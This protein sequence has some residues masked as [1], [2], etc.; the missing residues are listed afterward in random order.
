MVRDQIISRYPDE[1]ALSSAA[2]R[3]Q[4][5]AQS[6]LRLGI[7]LVRSLLLGDTFT[8]YMTGSSNTAGH[9]N[10]FMSTWPMQFQSMMRPVWKRVGYKGA[11]FVVKNHAEGGG[12]G[13]MELGPCIPSLIGD[14]A[15]V[16]W[17]ESRMNDH[18]DAVDHA[19]ENHFRNAITLPRRPLYHIMT[20]GK[21]G[22]YHPGTWETDGYSGSPWVIDPNKGLL[23]E[24]YN[25]YVLESQHL[26]NRVS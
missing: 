13:T 25:D 24:A 19:V 10:M 11:A 6:N 5:T 21:N 2:G 22:P 4:Y 15:D 9:E 26:P 14:D 23:Q 7:R 3:H 16:V 20:A 18:G 8:V 12:L 1:R 17:W